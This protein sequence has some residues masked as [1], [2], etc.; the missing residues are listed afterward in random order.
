MLGYSG[1]DLIPIRYIDSDF[2]SDKD[3][4]K[5]TSGSVFTFGGGAIV[6]RNIKQSFI[7]DSTMEFEYVVACENAKEAVWLCMFLT[8]LK[9]VPDMDKPLTLYFDNIGAMV[10]LKEPRSH[11]RGKQLEGEYHLIRE[12][13]H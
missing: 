13:V 3:S 11:K 10:N 8:D 2:Q 9:V 5:S 6:W 1:R 7:A 4:P 12:I